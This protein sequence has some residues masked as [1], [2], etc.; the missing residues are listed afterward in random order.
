M[1]CFVIYDDQYYVI[2][3]INIFLIIT[4]IFLFFN[5]IF[6]FFNLNA[7]NFLNT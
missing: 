3:Q 1:L 2:Y 5:L 6:L 7:G 4:F